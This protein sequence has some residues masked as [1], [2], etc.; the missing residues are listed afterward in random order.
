LILQQVTI[1]DGVEIAG[2]VDIGAGAK[3]NG[4]VRIGAHARIGYNAVVLSDVPSGATAVGVPAR[5]LFK[6]VPHAQT[7]HAI[8][9]EP[10][11]VVT[12]P[13]GSEPAEIDSNTDL[14]KPPKPAA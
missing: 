2:H 6:G 11:L 13:H 8:R 4:N 14:T 3:I 7:L 5:N 1:C 12:N 9:A 10:I